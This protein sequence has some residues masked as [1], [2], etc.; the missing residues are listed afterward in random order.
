MSSELNTTYL[1][2]LTNREIEV[3]KLL[4]DGVSNHDI[5]A[6]L[7]LEVS[8]V[9]WH[10]AQIYEKLQVRNRR[11][12]VIRAQTL[13]V[14]KVNTSSP[15]QQI[16]H[17]LPADT[18][19][20]I[21]RVEEIHELVQQL[22]DEKTRLVTILGAGGM[23]KTRL[24]IEVGRKLLAHFSDGVYFISLA[25]VTSTKQMI[26]TLVG[27]IS[28]KLHGD[29]SPKQQ[30]LDHL[31][32][33]HM[34][35]ITDNFEHLVDT[36]DFLSEILQSAAKVVVLVTSREKLNLAGERVHVLT[37]LSTP[38]EATQTLADYDAV[39]LFIEGAQRTGVA[40]KDAEMATVAR[41]C[42]L[43]AGM[44]LA[45]LLAA[46]WVDTLSIAE[47]EAE[48]KAGLGILEA[49][50]RDAP[51]RHQSIH[52]AF[53][54][55]W[56]RLSHHEQVVFMR[57]SVFQGGF[58]REAAQKIT[59]ANVRDLQRLVHTSF[60]QLLPLGRYVIH[61]LMRQYGA[62][63]LKAAG[64]LDRICKK[65]AQFFAEFVT[66]LG[67]L[68]WGMASREMLAEFNADFDN[69]RAAWLFQAEQKNTAE[70]RRFLDGIW[71]FLDQYTR[72]QEGI[73]LF[74]PLLFVFNDNNDDEILFRG[75]LL[76]RLSWF[77]SDTGHHQ[78]SLE[79]NEQALP[80]VQ[81]FNSTNDILLMYNGLHLLMSF[82]N[83]LEE[84]TSYLVRGFELAQKTADSKW[85]VTYRRYMS[86]DYIVSGRYEEA[87][88]LVEL[89]PEYKY[90]SFTMNAFLQEAGEYAQSEELLLQAINKY[91]FHRID[92]LQTH[93]ILISCATRA[94]NTEKAWRYVQRGLQ[95]G[96]DAAYAWGTFWVLSETLLLLIA[97]QQYRPATE[98]LSFMLHHPANTEGQRAY[99][100]TQ[101]DTLKTNLPIDE[102]EAAWECGKQLDLGDVITEYMER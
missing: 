64:E 10:N 48:I 88:R 76:A 26:T 75:Q 72:T 55:S 44:P 38:L 96:D 102:F 7:Y 54:V 57:L 56:K 32:Q 21:G 35:L 94:G 42:R 14:L 25:T 24:S 101:I 52:A 47:I 18:L 12:A 67:E 90:Q 46:A 13:G 69:V 51:T 71:H 53:D 19:P 79:L 15:F 3:L 36:A 68:V 11:Q 28:L 45:L 49:S 17:K 62:E 83:K 4:A 40:V 29:K 95:Y 30:L 99:A 1:E 98:L 43:V 70:L 39:K 84:S 66:P 33:L 23:G 37:G 34:L 9:K 74:E 80:I 93:S 41:I 65:H 86:Q 2:T 50:L 5:A 97:E 8:T 27:I 85:L 81:A 87:R 73:E 89:L 63:K 31:Q 61:E 59:G 20:F 92:Y 58:T 78:K 100:S 6:A 91:H 82:M 16:Q 60:I 22:A 77:Y